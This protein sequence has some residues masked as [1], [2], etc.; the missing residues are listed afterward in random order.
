MAPVSHL[1]HG[2][3]PHAGHVAAALAPPVV[4][5]APLSEKGEN[6]SRDMDLTRGKLKKREIELERG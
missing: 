6:L 3:V 2:V 5:N 4:T 1:G